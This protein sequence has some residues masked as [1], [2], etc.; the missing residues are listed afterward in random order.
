[1]EKS[2][3]PPYDPCGHTKIAV[4]DYQKSY[5]FYKDIFEYLGYRQVSSKDNRAGWVS[6]NGYG[7]LISQAKIPSYQYK[8]DAPGIHHLCLKAPTVETVDKIYQS[9]LKK[10]SFVFDAPKKYPDYTDKY[11]SIYFTDPDGI[12]LE[13]AYY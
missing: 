6:P 11:Y 12:K 4:S 1:M 10:N 13:V 5:S 2:S 7:V 3:N 8:L 9:L